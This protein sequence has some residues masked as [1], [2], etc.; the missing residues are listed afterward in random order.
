MYR[1]RR[2]IGNLRAILDFFSIRFFYVLTD[3]VN[4]ELR[5]PTT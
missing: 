5:M 3:G 1:E 4:D 2:I